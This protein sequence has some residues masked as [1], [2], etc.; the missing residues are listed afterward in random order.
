MTERQP[1]LSLDGDSRCYLCLEVCEETSPCECRQPLHRECLLLLQRKGGGRTC[2]I[3]RR[4]FTALAKPVER[5]RGLLTL[6]ACYYV[7]MLLLYFVVSYV[8]LGFAGIYLLYLTGVCDYRPSG[9]A[10][11]LALEDP[12]FLYGYLLMQAFTCIAVACI[13]EWGGDR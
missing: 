11:W 10:W 4:P 6:Q 3:C 8:I 2:T 5:F 7:F 9:D 12:S 1:L 13:R